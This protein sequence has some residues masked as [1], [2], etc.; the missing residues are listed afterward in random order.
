[1]ILK[2]I[3]AKNAGFGKKAQLLVLDKNRKLNL[4]Q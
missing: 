3:I 4:S 2:N 1:M